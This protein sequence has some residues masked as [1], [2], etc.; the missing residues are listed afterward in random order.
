[1]LWDI[2]ESAQRMKGKMTYQWRPF[3]RRVLISSGIAVAGFVAPARAQ[4]FLYNRAGFT[5][6]H[7]PSAVAVADFNHDQKLDL[8]VA[9]SADNTVSVLLG[10]NT[11]GPKADYVVGSLPVALVAG[12]F[13]GDKNVDLAV[14][15]ENSNTVSILLGKGDGTF[16]MRT[17]YSTG[18]G[19]V[20]IVVADFNGDKKMDLAV[21]NENDST[22]SILLGN[23]DGSF[24]PPT[25]VPVDTTPTTLASGDFNGDRKIDLIS[26]NVGNGTVTVLLSHGNGTFSRVDSPSGASLTPITS[27][28]AVGD[29]NRDGKTD[30]IV[31]SEL[32]SLNLLLGNG[33]GSFHAPSPIPNTSGLNVGAMR[34]GRFNGDTFLD[35]ACATS[36]GLA[37]LP[38]NGNGTFQQPIISAFGG[39]ITSM[40]AADFNGDGRLDFALADSYLS[41]VDVLLGNGKGVYGGMSTVNLAPGPGGPT[42]RSQR[43]STG[44]E[45]WILLLRRSAPSTDRYRSSL[46]R[47]TAR[48]TRQECPR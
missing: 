25:D 2:V 31:S 16:Q 15:N 19:P 30:V 43:T 13:N 24:Q 23:G 38:G 7:Y 27:T 10:T 45:N 39:A 20:A 14:V 48:S 41:T 46:A 11:F 1:M 28:L 26:S 8:A 47:A 9:N 33:N 44:M 32:S 6:G 35:I 21:V 34:V 29:F 5:I 17:D 22:V 40:A 37:I 12:D 4:N 42:G 36:N 3:A 18:N